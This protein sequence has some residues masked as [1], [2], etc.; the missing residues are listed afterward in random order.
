[1]TVLAQQPA[2]PIIPNP[3]VDDL[4][5]QLGECA[6]IQFRAVKQEQAYIARIRELEKELADAIAA[7]AANP[8]KPIPV[9]PGANKGAEKTK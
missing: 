2:L 3:G 5:M 7:S 9:T 6:I 1:M 8:G 4:K